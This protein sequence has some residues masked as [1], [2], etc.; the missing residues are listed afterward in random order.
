MY[1]IIIV[2]GAGALGREGGLLL[3]KLLCSSYGAAGW[4]TA[5]CPILVPTSGFSSLN[6]W[7]EPECYK[8][9]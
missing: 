1:N 9:S 5:M 3:E 8:I 6:I 7:L 2:V 4:W